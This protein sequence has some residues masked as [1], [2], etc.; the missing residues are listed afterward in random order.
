M[1]RGPRNAS[2]RSSRLYLVSQY[3]IYRRQQVAHCPD[4]KRRKTA[5][6]SRYSGLPLDGGVPLLPIVFR[7]S[8]RSRTRRSRIAAIG[9]GAET[10]RSVS[11]RRRSGPIDG[12]TRETDGYRQL[13]SSD[14]RI[15]SAIRS[16]GGRDSTDSSSES[17]QIP[18]LRPGP[19]YRLGRSRLESL[20]FSRGSTS[21]S[22]GATRADEH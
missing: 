17:V 12:S 21:T 11:D 13:A 15:R 7:V 19:R 20:S 6:C 18:A 1:S 2:Q 4:E 14:R 22:Y 9:V 8:L 3:V 5:D 16:I 10:T